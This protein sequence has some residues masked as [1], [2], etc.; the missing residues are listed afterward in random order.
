MRYARDVLERAVGEAYASDILTRLQTVI[1]ANPFDFLRPTPP[2]QIMAFL[3]NEHPQTIALVIANLPRTEI[4]AKVMALLAPAEQADVAV[5]IALMGHTPPDV[6][7]EVATVMRSKLDTVASQDFAAAGGVPGLAQILN[8]SDRAMERNILESLAH[9]NEQLAEEVRSLLFVFEDIL[10]LD[11]RAIQLV[12]K[13]IDPKD[14]ALALRG[15]SEEVRD[16]ILK[17]MSQRGADMLRE[18]MEYM[19]P[20]RRRVVEESQSKIV[21]AVR[22]LEET[23]AIVVSRSGREDELVV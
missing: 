6:V 4:A 12:L 23:D 10:K 9:E 3:R 19:P 11:D 5:R 21:A 18:E 17:N 15:A 2:D 7:K 20:Q 14:L 8:S 1:E 13:E 16:R 22:R